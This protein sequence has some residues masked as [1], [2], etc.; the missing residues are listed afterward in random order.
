MLLERA[1]ILERETT[2]EALWKGAEDTF[3][4]IN[5][6]CLMV[7]RRFE[8]LAALNGDALKSLTPRERDIIVRIANGATRKECAR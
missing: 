3:S 8:E 5:G 2:Q 7:H 6:F 4:E 1:A